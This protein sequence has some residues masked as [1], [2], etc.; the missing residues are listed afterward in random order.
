MIDSQPNVQPSVDVAPQAR[1]AILAA[2]LLALFLSSLDQTVVGTALPR[3]VT[4]LH[5]N[6]LYTWVV[7]AYLL[8][9]TI[10]VPIY[11]KFSDVFGRKPMLLIGVVVFLVGSAL[12]G[13]SQSMIQL[14]AFRALQG[15][16]AGAL[17][18]VSLAIIGDLFSPRE[19]GRYQGLF[20]AV[21]GL[22]FILGPFIGGVLTDNASWRW[23]F[24]VNLP[25]GVV[26][27]AVITV[28]LPNVRRGASVRDL[29]YL[30][31]VLFT[32][33]VIPLLVGLTNKG[34]TDSS[35]HL[36]GWV[37]PQVGLL[38]LIAAVFLTL[39]LL[40]ERRA[41]E[42]II[43]LDLFRDRSYAATN[44]ATFLVAVAMFA[45]VIYLP[46]Y[47]QA[48]RGVSATQS[49]Y[50]IWPLLVGLIGGSI[51]SGLL[52][53]RTGKYKVI[54]LSAMVSL[55]VGNLLMTRLTAQTDS[56]VLWSWMLLIGLGV[57]PAMAGYTVVVQSIVPRDRLGV[58][59]S[60]LTFL[61]QIGGSVGLALAGTVFTSTFASDLP[62][63]L[64]AASVPAR[65]A[66]RI[67]NQFGGN[68]TGVGG[69]GK[70]VGASL[71][72]QFQAL[73]PH[74]VTG[75][76]DA[77]AS[78]VAS[79]FWLGAG[80]GTLALVTALFIREVPLRGTVSA[81]EATEREAEVAGP[82]R[83]EPEPAQ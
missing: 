30:G 63:K 26:A 32:V 29:D 68:L 74:I 69:I 16:G 3:I 8:A 1:G 5:G 39:F 66:T 24:Y 40:V 4:D 50:E 35:G 22:S 7:T 76:H 62:G 59:T 33:G 47:Y 73:V 52:I 2:V 37:S 56:V 11:G 81:P 17:F 57:G 53:S 31:I 27:L 83:T 49:G 41:R 79:L 34:Q 36:Y 64:V 9:S 80:A 65:V 12:S 21:F 10:T 60:T 14:V 18:P 13:L 82:A 58:A 20:G 28:V 43:P 15:L 25:V 70:Q 61:R 67:A 23:V 38:L 45:A 42:P 46:R 77:V 54:L 6:E 72:P 51:A 55:I 71:P 48:V 19:R 78:A 75:I 44:V